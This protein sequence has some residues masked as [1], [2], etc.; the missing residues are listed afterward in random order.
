LASAK[1]IAVY[2][3]IRVSELNEVLLDVRTNRNNAIALAFGLIAAKRYL[4]EV[5][6][7]ISP[8]Q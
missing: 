1:D 6:R 4:L 3:A 5:L 7:D 8:S 2:A